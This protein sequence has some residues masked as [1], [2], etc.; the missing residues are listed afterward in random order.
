[1]IGEE[2]YLALRARY[3]VAGH[4]VAPTTGMHHIQ[5]YVEFPEPV[6]F[7]RIKK[8]L[9]DGVHCTASRGSAKDNRDYCTK[10]DA[11][12]LE[13]GAPAAQGAR[14]D[15]LALRD[16]VRAGASDKDL[17]DNDCV[18]E[19]A[20]K[21]IRSVDRM[22]LA[23]GIGT[24]Q[25]TRDAIRVELW[26]GPTGTGKSRAAR[27]LFPNAYWK[28]QS[29]WW[30]GYA[31]Q[32]QVV[33]D[34]FSGCCCTPTELNLILDRYPHTVQFKGGDVALRATTIILISNY[35]P[36]SWWGEKTRFDLP[37]LARRFTCVVLFRKFGEI[38]HEFVDWAEFDLFV[39]TGRL[40]IPT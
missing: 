10:E 8:V 32:E 2:E 6:R 30:P 40:N 25:P 34:E 21:Y 29:M 24:A 33:W 26:Y 22:R 35:P 17:F 20:I 9:G 27:E 18:C 1:M 37:A 23:Y 15:I 3:L 7:A 16:E 36:S 11:H 38:P 39:R 31:G 14:S 12:F 19:P 5:G 4:E 13:M 28:N